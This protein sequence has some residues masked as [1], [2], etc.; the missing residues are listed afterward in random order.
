[1]KIYTHE[2]L[3][4]LKTLYN[5]S[6]YKTHLLDVDATQQCLKHMNSREIYPIRPDAESVNKALNR[7]VGILKNGKT[8]EFDDIIGCLTHKGQLLT[9]EQKQIYQKSYEQWY[10]DCQSEQTSTAP[11]KVEQLTE[12]INQSAETVSLYDRLK[13]FW[14]HPEQSDIENEPVGLVIIYPDD[15]KITATAGF[16]QSGYI[17]FYYNPSDRIWEKDIG[18]FNHEYT[19]FLTRQLLKDKVDNFSALSDDEKQS[20][21]F[22]R[23]LSAFPNV[24]DKLLL[25]VDETFGYC[26]GAVAQKEYFDLHGYDFHPEREIWTSD[27]FVGI[28]TTLVS[29]AIYPLYTTYLNQGKNIDDTFWQEATNILTHNPNIQKLKSFCTDIN[30]LTADEFKIFNIK[31]TTLMRPYH[32]N[33]MCDENGVMTDKFWQE[34]RKCLKER[35]DTHQQIHISKERD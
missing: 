18:S 28:Q 25:A 21:P 4:Y 35:T 11:E 24:K 6:L 26:S 33:G 3:S 13:T 31:M 5:A 1:M 9:D 17:C 29:R 23:F 14:K 12:L 7:V 8:P 30:E 15:V 27:P 32:V 20:T 10:C 16:I 22:Y 19:H 2:W 34:M